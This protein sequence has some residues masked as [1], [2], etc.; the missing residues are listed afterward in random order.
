MR[1]IGADELKAERAKTVLAGALDG[2]QLRARHPQRRMRL[3]HRLWHHIAQRNVEILAVM[4]AAAVLEHREDG[5]Y[6][7]L[8]HFLLGFHVAAERRQFGDR[9]ALAHAEFAAAVAQQIEHRDALGDARGMIGGEL[10]DAVAEPDVP[11]ALGGG[12]EEGFRRRRMRIFFQE[13][14]LHHPGMVVA[15]AVG[16]LQLR[17]RVLVELQF[18]AGLPRARQLQLI[19]DAEFHDVSPARRLLLSVSVFPDKPKSS[20]D[21][22]RLTKQA[23]AR[24][25]SPSAQSRSGHRGLG[26]SIT[27]LELI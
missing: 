11:G 9:G 25:R 2:R 10:K 14:M 23:N 6:R 24:F 19:E 7:L 15:A 17:Q 8:E 3:L 22:F 5:A 16:G 4:L 18:V 26:R 27:A 21:K 12:G 1:G 20:L 13:M